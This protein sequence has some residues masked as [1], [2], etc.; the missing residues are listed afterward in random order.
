VTRGHFEEK[1]SAH[2]LSFL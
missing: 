2:H 1:T